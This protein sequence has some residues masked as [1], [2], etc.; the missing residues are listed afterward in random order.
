M[1]WFTILAIILGDLVIG[2][3]YWTSD[4]SLVKGD[5]AGMVFSMIQTTIFLFAFFLGREQAWRFVISERIRM[6]EPFPI[7]IRERVVYEIA[8]IAIVLPVTLYVWCILGAPFTVKKDFLGPIFM[9]V[10]MLEF[11]GVCCSLGS[12]AKKR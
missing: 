1:S 12:P 9:T 11:I 5:V 6:F 3:Y 7:P 10:I 4:L 2:F 8:Y